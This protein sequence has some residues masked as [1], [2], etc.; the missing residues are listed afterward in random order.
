VPSKI[1]QRELPIQDDG[2]E[3]YETGI[4]CLPTWKTQPSL[5]AK[6]EE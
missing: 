3:E 4:P 2:N 1:L 5:S 6:D